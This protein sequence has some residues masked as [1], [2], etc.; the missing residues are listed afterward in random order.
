MLPLDPK[1]DMLVSHPL[2]QLWQLCQ[3]VTGSCVDDHSIYQGQDLKTVLTQYKTTYPYLRPW[4]AVLFWPKMWQI[5]N[6]L[7][8]WIVSEEELIECC[9]NGLSVSDKK[10]VASLQDDDCSCTEGHAQEVWELK[11]KLIS[12]KDIIANWTG[13]NWKKLKVY[14]DGLSRFKRMIFCLGNFYNFITSNITCM[15]LTE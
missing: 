13:R 11:E 7:Q 15:C 8:L 14:F 4:P 5:E 9:S 2:H 6:I 1:A 10:G 3:L 12:R